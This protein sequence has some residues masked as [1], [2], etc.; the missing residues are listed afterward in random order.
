M[1]TDSAASLSSSNRSSSPFSHAHRAHLANSAKPGSPRPAQRPTRQS[2]REDST[3]S[4]RRTPVSTLLQE[5]LQTQRQVEGH[6]TSAAASNASKSSS[7]MTTS[8][9]ASSLHQTCSSK[10]AGSD[11]GRQPLRTDGETGQG[12]G[13]ALKEME[14]VVSGLHKQNFDLKLELYHRRERQ[15]ALEERMEALQ[16]EK[17]EVEDMND[18]LISELEKRDKAVEEAVAM[19][20]MLEEKVDTL[21]KERN[22]VRHVEAQSLFNAA[23]R[24]VPEDPSYRAATPERRPEPA[25]LHRVPS[26]MSDRSEATENL[27]NV[28]TGVRGSVVS[29]AR[30][31]EGTS[32]L[33]DP[34]LDSPSLSVLSKSSF[35]SVY[36]SNKRN[37]NAA[38]LADG[39]PSI[40]GRLGSA[41]QIQPITSVIEDSPLQ[42]IERMDPSYS[43]RRDLS[44]QSSSSRPATAIEQ[45]KLQRMASRRVLR[46]EKRDNLA[47][48][49][50]D[51]P[52]GNGLNDRSNDH[53]NVPS[54]NE[55]VSLKTQVGS[56]P[57]P[58]DA[59]TIRR[60]ETLGNSLNQ[61]PRSIPQRPRSAD[62]STISYRRDRDYG[63][64]TEDSEIDSFASKQEM[65]ERAGHDKREE[66]DLFGFAS[67]GTAWDHNAGLTYTSSIRDPL[68]LSF[69]MEGAVVGPTSDQLYDAIPAEALPAAQQTSR[70]GMK[71]GLKHAPQQRVAKRHAQRQRRNSDNGQNRDNMKTP[72]QQNF[73]QQVPDAATGHNKQ[74]PPITTQRTRDAVKGFWRRSFGGG[75]LP[76]NTPSASTATDSQDQGTAPRPAAGKAQPEQNMGDDPMNDAL[77]RATP[78]PIG[79]KRPSC[80]NANYFTNID[81]P[82]T[83]I[84]AVSAHTEKVVAQEPAAAGGGNPGRQN[85]MNQNNGMGQLYS[86]PSLDP[87]PFSFGPANTETTNG[88]L[89][90]CRR[91]VK[92]PLVATSAAVDDLNYDIAQGALD[93]YMVATVL[94]SAAVEQRSR[95]GGYEGAVLVALATSSQP[96]MEECELPGVHVPSG[97][98]VCRGQRG[99][100]KQDRK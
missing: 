51:A 43:P 48:V 98:G 26:F 87:F 61:I 10:Y 81:R 79:D 97:D 45:P 80:N 6:R 5:K 60:T 35:V 49:N 78:A 90:S 16:V 34:D 71:P 93:A 73:T 88:L 44:R 82:T 27:R 32:E 55:G 68:S 24:P 84:T 36:P 72:V 17:S 19:I 13:L 42:R 52:G 91:K 14:H 76:Q 53:V 25:T 75:P 59:P 85:I 47:K 11:A 37:G 8:I 22:M 41:G 56:T 69:G 64:D 96:W 58:A 66:P 21:T 62:E 3:E 28:Y 94:R 12:K 100:S 23:Y 65:W 4:A 70:A 92:I 1:P 50:T 46:A 95:Y 77:S 15:T 40:R 63:F 86:Y 20:I 38:Y 29:L 83:A 74:Y 7:D 30:V 18:R 2:N 57:M 9:D 67:N 33:G 99:K 39:S 89:E 54:R 31:P